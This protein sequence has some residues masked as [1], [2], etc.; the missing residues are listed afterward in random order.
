MDLKEIATVSGKGGLFRLVKPTRS[1][2]IL[3]SIDEQKSKLVAG[4]Q[5]R[6]SIL[7]EISIYT[8]GKESSVQLEEVLAAIFEKYGKDLP[9]Q[10]KSSSEDLFSFIEEIVPQYDRERVYSSDIKKLVTWYGILVN[11]APDLFEKKQ[12]DAVQAPAEEEKKS[13]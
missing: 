12:E 6:V 1:G 13:S 3:E 7:K 9:V 4:P 10:P 8:T 11:H 5:Y 2:V